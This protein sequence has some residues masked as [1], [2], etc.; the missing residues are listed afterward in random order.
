MALTQPV[1]RSTGN[2]GVRHDRPEGEDRVTDM[3]RIF[4][5]WARHYLRNEPL[6]YEESNEEVTKRG[7]ELRRMLHDAF[8]TG[9]EYG[10]YDQ[11]T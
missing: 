10:A 11:S 7:R 2:V 5:R 1:A 3:E 8:E 9:Y 4:D 6:I